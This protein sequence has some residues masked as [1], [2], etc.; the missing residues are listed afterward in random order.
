MYDPLTGEGIVVRRHRPQR[1]R[2]RGRRARAARSSGCCARASASSSSST[3]TA[4]PRTCA[5]A[6]S[7]TSACPT[8]RSS[9]SRASLPAARRPLAPGYRLD[10]ERRSRENSASR[11]SSSE[12]AEERDEHRPPAEVADAF[13][14][15]EAGTAAPADHAADHA[16]DD[17]AEATHAVAARARRTAPMRPATNP[18][19]IQPRMLTGLDTGARCLPD[20]QVGPAVRRAPRARRAAPTAGGRRTSR[21]APR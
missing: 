5:P 12:R 11:I 16:D 1:G 20:E 2:A 21:S 14:A 6:P 13:V 17:R 8:R 3:P 7:P 10:P 4:A 19:T 15:G 18:T 9:E